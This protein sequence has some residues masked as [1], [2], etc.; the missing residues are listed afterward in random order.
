MSYLKLKMTK[1]TKKFANVTYF[2]NS[3]QPPVV[4]QEVVYQLST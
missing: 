2:C 1:D 4:Y 3:N